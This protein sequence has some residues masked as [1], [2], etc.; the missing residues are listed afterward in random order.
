MYTYSLIFESGTILAL[1]AVAY[2]E[3]KDRKT[4]EV[5]SLAFLYG[6]I[7]EALNI[8]MSRGIYSYNPA[9][10]LEIF[11]V[12]L[13][14]GAGWA[15]IFYLSR[16][17][18][19]RYGLRWWQSPFLTALIA[20]SYD[21]AMDAVA[22]RLGFWQWS[23]PLCEEWF[24]VPYDNFFGWLAVVWT[25]AL[26]INLSFRDFV[27]EKY[28][29]VLRYLSPVLSAL[30]LGFQIMIYVNLSAV[31]SGRYSW[32]EART[33]YDQGEYSFAYVPEVQEAKGRLL[34]FII[35]SLSVLSWI[36]IRKSK[37][38]R[39]PK[40]GFVL[41]VSSAVHLMLL[42][43]LLFSGIAND[44]PIFILVSI[45]ALAFGLLLEKPCLK[46]PIR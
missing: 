34:L 13:A 2:H 27:K 42:C 36:W 28:R 15:I 3:R 43:F 26:F 46:P 22:I 32:A 44:Y 4:I 39:R 38:I 33:L 9:F 12:P 30:L 45:S 17:I 11:G 31:L 35:L 8:H 5:V 14:I 10:A 18:A 20:L 1:L 19:G 23:I 41:W 21:L 7:L 25:F 29:R 6:M 37:D 16:S 40:D 24:G